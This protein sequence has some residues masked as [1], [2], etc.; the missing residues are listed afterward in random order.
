MNCRLAHGGSSSLCKT[1]LLVLL[2]LSLSAC[3]GE[4]REA[5]LR[6][7]WLSDTHIGGGTGQEDLMAAVRD[8]NRLEG[9]D[10]VIV[11]GDVT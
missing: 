8:I 2:A 11:S 7:A 5:L 1:G 4:R 9:M 10:F 3:Q 6:F